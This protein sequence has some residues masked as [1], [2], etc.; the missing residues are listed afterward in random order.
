M[1]SPSLRKVIAHLNKLYNLR[2]HVLAQIV[3]Q[4]KPTTGKILGLVSATN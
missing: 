3:W 4:N 2:F 1:L